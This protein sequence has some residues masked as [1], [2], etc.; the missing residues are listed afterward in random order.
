M[1]SST[2]AASDAIA[3]ASSTVKE[4]NTIFQT[5]L[6]MVEEL[7]NVIAD[8]AANMAEAR[9]AAIEIARNMDAST[10]E[11]SAISSDIANVHAS[12]AQHPP[13]RR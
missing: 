3:Q 9:R 12:A 10:G 13:Q 4:M 8:I 1:R 6:A 5:I 2:D 11:L 7:K